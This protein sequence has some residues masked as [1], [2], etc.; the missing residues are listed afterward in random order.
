MYINK[1]ER[2][3]DR[4]RVLFSFFFFR[5]I[6]HNFHSLEKAKKKLEITLNSLVKANS[7]ANSR[8]ETALGEFMFASFLVNLP[9]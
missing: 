2:E 4:E 6:S 3:R 1:L 8:I 7:V 9:A 5:N